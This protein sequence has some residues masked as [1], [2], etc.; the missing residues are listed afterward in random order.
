M[1]IETE[2]TLIYNLT[3]DLISTQRTIVII[4]CIFY[5]KDNLFS[6]I[7]M[8]ESWKFLFIHTIIWFHFSSI[9]RVSHSLYSLVLDVMHGLFILIKYKS[10][11]SNLWNSCKQLETPFSKSCIRKMI[12]K[13]INSII[14]YVL[15]ILIDLIISKP[16][17]NSFCYHNVIYTY[18]TLGESVSVRIN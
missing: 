18:V 3:I 16:N 15:L 8:L 9:S 14:W 10:A 5:S 4:F 1:F 11:S 7:Q 12:F 2:H 17:R 6:I 13:R